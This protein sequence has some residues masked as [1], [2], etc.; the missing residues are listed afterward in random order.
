MDM[1]KKFLK[2]VG[3]LGMVLFLAG[4]GQKSLPDVGE[5]NPQS[6]ST[7]ISSNVEGNNSDRNVSSE[8]AEDEEINL[9]DRREQLMEIFKSIETT[10][11]YKGALATNPIMTQAFGADPYAME[12]DGRL[13]IYMT[14]DVLEYKDGELVTN[15]YSTIQ[16]IHVVSTV[17]MMNFT[18]H[19]YIQVAGEGG[20]S[21]W[22]HNSWAPAAVWKNI[23]GKD[24]F[25]LYFADGGGGIG[26]LEGDSP[27]GPFVDPVGKG[28]LRRD[29]PNCGN[30]LW[31]FDP[32]V[33][34]DDDGNA[35]IYFGGG[36]PE[37]KVS[38][39]GT[40]RVAKLGADMI[41]I[42]GE[43]VAIDIPYLFE[44]SGIH[45]FN[46]KYYYTYCTNWQADGDGIAEA[47]F[48]IHNAE[49]AM[50]ESDSPMGP[51]EYKGVIMQNPG[52]LCGL[53]SNNHH[54][55]FN[56]KDQWYITYHAKTVEKEM[57]MEKGY[58]STHIDAF[59]IA[60]DGSIGKIK[61]T[62]DGRKQ[63]AYVDPFTTQNAAMIAREG[64]IKT[65][66][67]AELGLG[68]EK[69][70]L[71][72]TEIN[73]G[74]FVKVQGVDFAQ[75]PKKITISVAGDTAG[76]KAIAVKI[77]GM[78]GAITVYVDVNAQ[79]DGKCST[80]ITEEIT[81]VQ[82]VTFTFLGEGYQV[83]DWTFEK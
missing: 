69:N 42:E 70:V 31:L 40:G 11:S 17:D 41:S 44:D 10:K 61:M 9:V 28:L 45:K 21:K 54:A 49:I 55:I 62:M 71:A 53:W 3:I 7:E 14:D 37:G 5:N 13:Y 51:F 48:G 56:Y 60:P 68:S 34:V 82:D 20:A 1:K 47:Q 25:F 79:K 22:A 52:H 29:M 16:R 76:E 57:G 6:S 46:N 39:P 43:P 50:M 27:V 8:A 66:S 63:I 19:G 38:F 74:D 23:N 32:A 80:E 72:L 78:S 83:L 58:R 18:D 15:S 73:T 81:G 75:A 2:K 33:L 4:C 64:G 67:L 30:V 65:A 12:Y 36:V 77:G 35:Y 26:V 24:R 59:D